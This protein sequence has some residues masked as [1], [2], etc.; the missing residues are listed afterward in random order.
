MTQQSRE[1]LIELL[2]LALYLDQHLSVDEDEVLN[3]ALAS[4]GW[5]SDV[6]CEVFIF[7]AF[8]RGRE[9]SSKID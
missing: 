7:K 6:A 5:E 9:A 3:K 1:A 2:F 4:L 8:S